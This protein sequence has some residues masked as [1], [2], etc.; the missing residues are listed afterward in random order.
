MSARHFPIDRLLQNGWVFNSPAL[1]P[2]QRRELNARSRDPN[3]DLLKES[4]KRNGISTTLW[5]VIG[6]AHPKES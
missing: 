3:S 1:S 6:A 5:R 4:A 2:A